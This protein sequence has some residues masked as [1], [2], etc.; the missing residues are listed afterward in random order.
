MGGARNHGR[1]VA[2][3]LRTPLTSFIGREREL[4]ELEHLLHRSRLLTLTGAGGAGKTRLA[5][6]LARSSLERFPDGVWLVDLAALTDAAFLPQ[7]VLLALGAKETRRRSQ[8]EAVAARIGNGRAL[9]VIDNCE[10]LLESTANL[11][12]ALLQACPRLRIVTTSREPLGVDGEHTWRAP[13]L[14]LPDL[15]APADTDALLRSP[16]VRLLADRAVHVRSDFRATAHNAVVLAQICH[17]LDGIPL[18]IELAAARMALLTPQELLARLDDRFELLAGGRGALPR[19]RTLRA[20]VDWSYQLLDSAEATT[21]RRLSVFANGFTVADAEAVCAGPPIE[22]RELPLLLSRLLDKSLLTTDEVPAGHTRLG[23]LDTLRQYAQEKLFESGESESVRQRHAAHFRDLARE[24]DVKTTGPD[25][26]E[27]LDR[28]ELERDNLRAALDWLLGHDSEAC[29]Q[30]TGAL[31]RFWRVRGSESEGSRR[32]RAALDAAPAHT[33]ARGI[34]LYRLADIDRRHNDA[35]AG[36]THAGEAFLI[37]SELGETE[38][39]IQARIQLAWALVLEGDLAS[40]AGHLEAT[41][42]FAADHSEARLLARSLNELCLLSYYARDLAAARTYGEH[43]LEICR[44]LGDSLAVAAVLENLGWIAT[45]AGEHEE[46]R[47]HLLASLDL[48]LRVGSV[49]DVANAIQGLARVAAAT[50]QNRAALQLGAVA[51]TVLDELGLSRMA[52]F[53]RNFEESMQAARAALSKRAAEEAWAEGQRLS[54][55][56]AIR[57]VRPA[58]GPDHDGRRGKSLPLTVRESEVA[59]LV[60]RGMTNKEIAAALRISERTV[61]AHLEH[62][63]NKLGYHSRAEIAAWAARHDLEGAAARP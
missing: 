53:D 14:G 3:N 61:D 57:M 29:L 62:M 30:M 32:L 15:A 47:L 2:N 13:S 43:G 19:H 23:M 40:A 36:K 16:A 54:V 5:L 26:A 17:R 41:R 12:V 60:A 8:V 46:A 31:M 37:A 45:D 24:S 25:T 34:A 39:M 44:G 52:P 49:K 35:A 4:A 21:F 1:P 63:L 48:A 22:R 20:T 59:V 27:W 33:A 55:E 50:G 38:M 51:T 6:E 56:E 18:A 9:V 10:H 42:D 11:C 7:A 58:T 28:L